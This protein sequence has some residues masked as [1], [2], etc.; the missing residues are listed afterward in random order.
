MKNFTHIGVYF[1]ICL[2]VFVGCKDE[3]GRIGLGIQPE[4]E[5][6]NTDY[7][8]TATIVAY[9][10]LHDSLITSNVSVNMLGYLNDPI[11]GK[12]QAGIYTQFRLSSYNADFGDAV[13]VDSIVLTLVYAGF[14]GDTLNSF[15]INVYELSEKIEKNERY[16][17]TS[18]LK[19]IGENL[20]ENSNFSI[21]PQPTTRPDT[22]SS[23]CYFNIKLKKDFAE[24]KFISQSKGSVYAN[25]AN[26]LDYF[27]GLYLEASEITGS[28]GC[29]LSINMTHSL[30]RLTI[31]YKSSSS[32]SPQK[33]SFNMNDSTAH[34][35]V[36]NHFNYADANQNLREQLQDSNHASTKDVLYAQAGA[37]VKIAL[38]FPHLK[39][40]FE[41]KKVIIHRAALVISHKDDEFLP[42]NT[43]GLYTDPSAGYFLPDF[44]LGSDYF[45]GKYNQTK[46]EYVFNI[47]RHIQ[48]LVSGRGDNYVLNLSVSPSVTHFSRLTI[49]GTHPPDTD[50]RLKL[51]I[52]YTVVD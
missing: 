46:K 27:K 20:T 9:S 21:R 24:K 29:M 40:T 45:G 3:Q 35:G 42:P 37:G 47:T 19:Y 38:H 22:A 23:V 17:T 10:V 8:D 43:L 32:E 52:N 13:E 4:D 15:K 12:T 25:D 6:L 28:D 7:F 44:D 48:N 11:F 36:F 18:S 26:F 41:G 50:K 33:Y 30:S 1:S 34:F 14:Y 39:E 51:K 31:Y 2:L 16:Y 49:Y 5:F